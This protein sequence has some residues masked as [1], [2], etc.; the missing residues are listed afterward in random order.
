MI[1]NFFDTYGDI[2]VASIETD[3]FGEE[4]RTWVLS[5]T[6][7]GRKQNRS[8]T[9]SIINNIEKIRSND[10]FY[11]NVCDITENDRLLID[12][13]YYNIL[14]VNNLRGKHLQ[15]DIEKI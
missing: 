8:G 12:G 5:T 2:E 1:D 3:E 11:C 15:I 4:I 10:R 9:K 6:I 14:N 13:D 7:F